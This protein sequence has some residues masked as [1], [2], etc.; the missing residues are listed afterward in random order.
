M[1]VL[2]LFVGWFFGEW[3]GL[4]FVGFGGL[5]VYLLGFFFFYIFLPII[6]KLF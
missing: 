3:L 1:S 2:L 6:G 4:L 5:W